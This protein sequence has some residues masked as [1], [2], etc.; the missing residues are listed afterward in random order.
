MYNPQ[1]ETFLRVADAGSFNKAAEELFITP[2]AVMKQITSLEA[3]LDIQ[4]FRRSRGLTLTEAENLSLPGCKIHHPILQGIRGSGQK[5]RTEGRPAYPH[6]RFT[7]DAGTVLMDLWPSSMQCV[8]TSGFTWSIMNSAENAREILTNLGKTS[9][10][11][12]G[13]MTRIFW[14]ITN[15]PLWSF[16]DSD[17]MRGPVESP[18]GGEAYAVRPRPVWGAV[19][20][21]PAGL[22]S[23]S[24]YHA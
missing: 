3:S 23:I 18:A 24:G 22:E 17:C 6:R 13:C 14:N 8:R 9:T 10:S 16:Q 2:P 4:L 19:H 20:A 12:R 21:D 5:R 11:W 1:L 15:V 7:Y